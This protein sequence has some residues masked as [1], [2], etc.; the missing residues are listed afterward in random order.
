MK[1]YF[2]GSIR[3]GRKDAELYRTFVVDIDGSIEFI[4]LGVNAYSDN[5]TIIC[6][7][8]DR[9]DGS[10]HHALQLAVDSFIV[11][12]GQKCSFWHN[13]RI[14]V[15]RSGSGKA[16]DLKKLLKQYAQHL[17]VNDEIRLGGFAYTA[18]VFID[19]PQMVQFV[20]NLIN[21]SIVRDKYRNALSS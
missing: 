8:I 5:R 7:A 19:E 9:D 6:V 15:G 11:L 18:N 3:G 14:A 16:A 2:A 17:M 20:S 10:P 13:G 1:I 21:Y 4:S 12:D